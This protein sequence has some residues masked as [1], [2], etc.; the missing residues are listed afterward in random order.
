MAP[1]IDRPKQF[2]ILMSDDELAARTP[3][4][5]HEEKVAKRGYARLYS[6]QILQAD[7]GCDFSILTGR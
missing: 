4:V 1:P 5:E 3:T 2:H 7:E 6:E